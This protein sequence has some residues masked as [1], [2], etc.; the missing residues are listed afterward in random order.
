MRIERGLVRMPAL[1]EKLWFGDS[2]D[3]RIIKIDFRR[4]AS[5]RRAPKSIHDAK[6]LRP[7]QALMGSPRGGRCVCQDRASATRVDIPRRRPW[8]PADQTALM[9]KR[10]PRRVRQWGLRLILRAAHIG[11]GSGCPVPAGTVMF[12]TH[13]A[14]SFMKRG[15]A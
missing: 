5:C 6:I 7:T 14:A 1:R 8:Q 4:R 11:Y 15:D 12:H 10:L 2:S 13:A 9:S 3:W